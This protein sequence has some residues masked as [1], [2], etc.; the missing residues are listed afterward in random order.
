MN[1]NDIIFYD[2]ETTGVNPH[3]AQP[4]QLAAV[5]IDGRKLTID[6]KNIFD[7]YINIVWDE[8][9]CNRLDLTPYSDEIKRIT[10]I[11][12]KNLEPAPSLQ[13]VWEEFQQ[14]VYRNNP[15]KEKWK[16]PIRAGY[17]IDRYDNIIVDR[18]CGGHR[19]NAKMQ[20]LNVDKSIKIED[21]YGFGPWD[22]K[23][24]EDTLFNPRDSIDLL[25]IV[26]QWT[27][28]MADIKSLSFDSVRDWLGISAEGAHNAKKDVLDGAQT[29][30]RFLK[31][32]RHVA[33][34]IKFKG[35][36]NK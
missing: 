13:T 22:P 30:V 14:F 9:E 21:P 32:H 27:E 20:L 36:V 34:T 6:D 2:F 24:Q 25:R 28:N 31:L 10:G 19:R 33:P 18:I 29:L 5:M 23:R 7:S 8:D 11:D 12:K 16:S 26:W 4:I 1:Y 35:K 3:T 17:N 15:S